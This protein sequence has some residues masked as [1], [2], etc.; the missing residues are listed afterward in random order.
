MNLEKLKEKF[1][2]K[3]LDWRIGRSG[4]TNGKPWA[5]ALCYITARAAQ[6]RLDEVFGVGGWCDKYRW[7]QGGVVCSLSV[8]IDGEWVTK[9]NGSDQTD[10]EAFKGGISAAFKRAAS[11]WGIARYLY[12]LTESF[13]TFSDN[14]TGHSAKIEG[15]YYNWIPPK[16]PAWALP[17]SHTQTGASGDNTAA[18]SPGV[19]Q[20]AQTTAV[21]VPVEAKKSPASETPV[22][23]DMNSGKATRSKSSSSTSSKATP[24]F[25]SSPEPVPTTKDETHF[26]VSERTQNEIIDFVKFI[27]FPMDQVAP[28]IKAHFSKE[29]LAQL[30]EFDA[31]KL[32]TLIQLKHEETNPPKIKMPQWGNTKGPSQTQAQKEDAGMNGGMPKHLR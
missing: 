7:E 27:K 26:K 2:E 25:R 14:K 8:K 31:R 13:V 30:S 9:E 11:T 10:I 12:D 5:M 1:P 15:K 3:D 21:E 4:I 29:K 17:A 28:M 32:K 6:D 24:A 18:P 23:V 19:K 16:L 22:A 20:L